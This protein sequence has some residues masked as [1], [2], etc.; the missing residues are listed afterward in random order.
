MAR[1]DAHQLSIL[2]RSGVGAGVIRGAGVHVVRRDHRR[3]H[4]QAAHRRHHADPIHAAGVRAGRARAPAPGYGRTRHGAGHAA[5]H[6]ECVRYPDATGVH[7][8][9]RREGR[10]D[11]RHRAQLLDVQRRPGGRPGDR[12]GAD[13]HRGRRGVLSAERAELHRGDRRLARH[14]AAAIRRQA[15]RR[16]GVGRVSRNSRVPQERAARQHAGAAHL[17]LQHLRIS[18]PRDDAGVRPRRAARTGGGLWRCSAPWRSPS[19]A[20]G[21]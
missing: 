21:S 20:G 8:G 12:G 7:R 18:L 10:P 11:E 13:R 14:A 6:R 9:N 2:R 17:G 19:T 15:G 5:R 1:P 4:R 16:L 3:S